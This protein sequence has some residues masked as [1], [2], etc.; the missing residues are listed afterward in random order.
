LFLKR[1]RE[2]GQEKR[3]KDRGGD[4]ELLRTIWVAEERRRVE[5]K[6]REGSSFLLDSSSPEE[7]EEEIGDEDVMAFPSSVRSIGMF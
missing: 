2:D 1:V 6:E 4:D 5:R 3:W 7:E